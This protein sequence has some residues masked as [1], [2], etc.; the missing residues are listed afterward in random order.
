MWG[1]WLGACRSPLASNP[2]SR[3]SEVPM[4]R[5]VKADLPVMVIPDLFSGFDFTTQTFIPSLVPDTDAGMDTVELAEA[6]LKAG[7]AGVLAEVEEPAPA[8]VES[9]WDALMGVE[10]APTLVDLLNSAPA[11]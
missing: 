3:C 11:A 6:F 4:K 8:S 1:Q 10:E 7:R 5:K 2:R 9:A